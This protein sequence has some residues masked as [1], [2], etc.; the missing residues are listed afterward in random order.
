V[1][2]EIFGEEELVAANGRSGAGCRQRHEKSP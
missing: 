1:L 2:I